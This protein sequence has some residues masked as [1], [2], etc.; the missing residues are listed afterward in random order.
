MYIY[1][2]R[3]VILRCHKSTN[4]VWWRT[5]GLEGHSVI[6]DYKWHIYDYY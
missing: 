2:L 1:K 3:C 6:P 5:A 4:H